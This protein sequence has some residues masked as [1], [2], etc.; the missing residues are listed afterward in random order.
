DEPARVEGRLCTDLHWPF[1]LHSATERHQVH[2]GDRAYAGLQRAVGRPA[3]DIRYIR[4]GGV[5]HQ[6]SDARLPARSLHHADDGNSGGDR[7]GMDDDVPSAA[8][9]PQLSPL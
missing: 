8:R 6:I 3:A 9:Y 7:A 1:E 5:S 4:G 2:R